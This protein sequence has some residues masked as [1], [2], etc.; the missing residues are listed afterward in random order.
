[1][2]IVVGEE[3]LAAR[4]VALLGLTGR[5][6][7]FRTRDAARNALLEGQRARA[8]RSL[9][10]LTD[11][12][13]SE[14]R[15][16][17]E[18]ASDAAIRRLDDITQEEGRRPDEPHDRS[19]EVVS[20]AWSDFGARPTDALTD[21]HVP[22]RYSPNRLVA[23]LAG[24]RRARARRRQLRANASFPGKAS[25]VLSMVGHLEQHHARDDGCR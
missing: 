20:V 15:S 10:W 7:L 2:A 9:E 12:E 6:P 11:A 1:M 25:G 22:R 18:A 23:E 14:A 24:R 8:E 5:M 21:G 4:L 17:A 13:L 3:T 16:D 19:D